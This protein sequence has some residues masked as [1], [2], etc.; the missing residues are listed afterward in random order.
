MEFS[1]YLVYIVYSNILFAAN[2][3]HMNIY[4]MG[5][6]RFV[7]ETD[8]KM[9][10]NFGANIKEINHNHTLS[11]LQVHTLSFISEIIFAQSITHFFKIFIWNLDKVRWQWTQKA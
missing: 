10:Y 9:C 6:E 7:K 2:L 8:A 11:M 5:Y 1:L 4:W 3:G